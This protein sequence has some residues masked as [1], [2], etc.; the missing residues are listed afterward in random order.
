MA[1]LRV[2]ITIFFYVIRLS[3]V[4]SQTHNEL[5]FDLSRLLWHCD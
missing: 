5:R 4:T 3:P 2:H 1:L